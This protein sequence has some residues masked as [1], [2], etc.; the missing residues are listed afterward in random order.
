MFLQFLHSIWIPWKTT[1]TIGQSHR[2]PSVCHLLKSSLSTTVPIPWPFP[3]HIS[4]VVLSHSSPWLPVV[5]GDKY[6]FPTL[7]TGRHSSR[8]LPWASAGVS[9][10]SQIN[11]LTPSSIWP[12]SK[13]PFIS[14]FLHPH[15]SVK[16]LMS[17]K[18][19]SADFG[20]LSQELSLGLSCPV[21]F[22]FVFMALAAACS[23][24]YASSWQILC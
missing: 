18:S 19:T 24:L 6:K 9:C 2:H 7:A 1:E 16:S 14:L 15:V 11:W 22:V 10:Y 12:S 20:N 13:S 17:L 3:L 23:Q 8:H 21:Y 4:I 5:Y